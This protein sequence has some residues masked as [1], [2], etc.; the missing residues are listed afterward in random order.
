MT[1]PFRRS[2]DRP[3]RTWM[4]PSG[5]ARLRRPAPGPCRGA[6]RWALDALF[7]SGA[8]AA[9]ACCRAPGAAAG[10]SPRGACPGDGRRPPRW[11]GTVPG[12]GCAPLSR[13][14][15]DGAEPREQ[16]LRRRARPLAIACR[17]QLWSAT[18]S[19]LSCTPPCPGSAPARP[20]TG[21]HAQVGRRG[22]DRARHRRPRGLPD[23]LQPA[24]LP[25]SRPGRTAPSVE[26]ARHSG[27]AR[28]RSARRGAVTLVPFRGEGLRIAGEDDLVLVEALL[29]AQALG[30]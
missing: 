7:L 24:G 12:C 15:R 6:R 17:R 29:H 19:T 14:P 25:A 3:G 10:R 22:R 1:T 23:D 16:M 13:A 27:H 30:H 4:T 26:D 20:V 21:R 2:R 8:R 5:S 11:S 28:R 18:S 9:H